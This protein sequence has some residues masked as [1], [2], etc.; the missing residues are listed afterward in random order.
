ME[1]EGGRSLRAL[2]CRAE[3]P[4][5]RTDLLGADAR[6]R[7]TAGSIDVGHDSCQ[8]TPRSLE[9]SPNACHVLD[10]DAGVARCERPLLCSR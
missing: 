9:G 2:I 5:R 4:A 6:E 10:I 1:R 8:A 3:A 7:G